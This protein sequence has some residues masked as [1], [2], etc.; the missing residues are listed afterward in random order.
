MP[1]TQDS[2]TV[3]A[4]TTTSTTRATG[5]HEARRKPLPAVVHSVIS[6]VRRLLGAEHDHVA[7]EGSEHVGHV[8]N[9]TV[10]V[11]EDDLDGGFVAEC[12]E[13]PGCVAQGE[14][15]EEALENL[16]DAAADVI[17]ARMQAHVEAHELVELPSSGDPT[18][19]CFAIPV[20]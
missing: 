9:L 5:A 16:A 6:T 10:K 4:R 1:I 14:T 20:T 15:A 7:I 3:K 17:A 18:V 13:L 8:W 12:A 2:E 11:V 19:R